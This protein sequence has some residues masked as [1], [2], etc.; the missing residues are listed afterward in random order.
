MGSHRR[1]YEYLTTVSDTCHRYSMYITNFLQSFLIAVLFSLKV[2]V[3]TLL[4]ALKVQ[5]ILT[6]TMTHMVIEES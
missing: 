6:C 2:Y 1:Q 5:G 4:S 3:I